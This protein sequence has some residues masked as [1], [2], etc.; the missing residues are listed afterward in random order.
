[1]FQMK[2][3]SF[4]NIVANWNGWFLRFTIARLQDFLGKKSNIDHT[5]DSPVAI[6]NG[7][8][9]ELVE[10]EKF[11][12]IHDCRRGRNR[13]DPFHHNIAQWRLE[14]RGKKPDRKSTRLN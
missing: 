13:D 7:K 9:E 10:H 4:E 3:E 14:R 6:D 12:R 11:A 8:G 1:M 2:T 5:H